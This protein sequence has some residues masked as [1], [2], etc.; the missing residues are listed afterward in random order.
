MTSEGIKVLANNGSQEGVLVES[1]TL[2]VP[3]KFLFYQCIDFESV[4]RALHANLLLQR[5][6]QFSPFSEPA[7][8]Q[9]LVGNIAQ[10]WFWDS[11]RLTRMHHEQD[12]PALNVVPETML[13]LPMMAGLRAQPCIEGWDLQYWDAGLLRHSRWFAEEPNEREK[14]DFVRVCAAAQDHA[15]VLGGANLLSK[16]WNEKPFWSKENLASEPVASRLILGVFLAWLFLQLG[17][18]FGAQIK[19]HYLSLRVSHKSE[20]LKELVAQRDGAINQQAFN[21]A[22]ADLAQ[23]PSQLH[24]LAQ[25][26][27]CLGDLSFSILE[28]QYQREQLTLLLQQENQDTRALVEACA[29]TPIF[30]DVRAEPGVTPNQTRLVFSLKGSVV[31]GAGDAQ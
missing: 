17:L 8:C 5:I 12:L 9:V 21:Q 4:P 22:I 27:T 26:R 20:Q 31:K 1:P 28:W 3:R 11:Q 7:S 30:S 2:I 14:A 16:P 15:W 19:E 24:L 6:R 10:V 25:V 18:N 29:K 23:S 13:Y